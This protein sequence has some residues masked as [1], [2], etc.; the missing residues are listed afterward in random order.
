MTI[1]VAG[2]ARLAGSALFRELTS[3]G[4]SV[5]GVS[6][7]DVDLI[8]RIGCGCTVSDFT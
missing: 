6:S 4:K 5:V 3:K 1:L 8:D 2:V 7:N